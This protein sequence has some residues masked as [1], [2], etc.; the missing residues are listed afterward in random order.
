MGMDISGLKSTGERG[1]YFRNSVW[2]WH[3]L[4]LYCQDVAPEITSACRDWHHNFTGDGLDAAGALALAE[5]LQKEIDTN[6]TDAFA[7]RFNSGQEMLPN[8]PC[9]ICDGTGVRITFPHLGAGDLKKG[10]IVCNK[11]QGAGNVRPWA[12]YYAFSTENVANFVAFL[13]ESGGFD[14]C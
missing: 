7:R 13:R 11:C 14:I 6:R 2:W 5:A 3:P 1:E 4:A 10:G 8:E 9:N 12:S